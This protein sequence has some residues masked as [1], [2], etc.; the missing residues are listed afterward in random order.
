MTQSFMTFLVSF[1]GFSFSDYP[2]NARVLQGLSLT[3]ISLLYTEG[4]PYLPSWSAS[5]IFMLVSPDLDVQS[6]PFV[7]L[8]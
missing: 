3:F 2:F 6:W 4:G 7:L 5:T 8:D 1:A